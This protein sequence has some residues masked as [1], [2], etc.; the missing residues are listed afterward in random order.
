MDLNK[1]SGMN[2]RHCR[3]RWIAIFFFFFSFFITETRNFSQNGG[4]KIFTDYGSN[5]YLSFKYL[6]FL[7]VSDKHTIP[8]SAIKILIYSKEFLNPLIIY[9]NLFCL[10]TPHRYMYY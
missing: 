10:N 9:S 1:K 6:C 8:L 5:W 4:L 2:I 7:Q 3:N